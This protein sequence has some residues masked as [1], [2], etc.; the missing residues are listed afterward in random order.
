MKI[1]SVIG[2]RPEFIKEAPL[3]KE[4]RKKQKYK[5]GWRET[6]IKSTSPLD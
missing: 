4:L 3:V 1:V 6:E 5:D 2:A